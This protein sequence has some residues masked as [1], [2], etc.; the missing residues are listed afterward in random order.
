[1]V[2]TTGGNGTHDLVYAEGLTLDTP[3][4]TR[5]YRLHQDDVVSFARAWDPQGFH[6]DEEVAATHGFGG[7]I[8]SDL[9]TAY[10]FQKLAVTGVYTNWAIIAAKVIGEMWLPRPV[11]SGSTLT[12]SVIITDAVP[13]DERRSLVQKHGQLW[14]RE[15][16]GSS[17]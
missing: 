8:V 4:R 7:L 15:G 10:I 16:D 14:D 17:R 12:G 3:Y 1:M 2:T 6:V 13:L 5:Q 9:K 11:R